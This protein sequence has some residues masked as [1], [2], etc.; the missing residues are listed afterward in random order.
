MPLAK[1]VGELRELVA[2][3]GAESEMAAFLR[4]HAGDRFANAS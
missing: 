4:Q 1:V 3:P 2:V